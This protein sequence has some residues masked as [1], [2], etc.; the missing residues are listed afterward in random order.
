MLCGK[1]FFY[2]HPV[3]SHQMKAA[4][5]ESKVPHGFHLKKYLE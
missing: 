5:E 2:L 4:L 1:H 3:T